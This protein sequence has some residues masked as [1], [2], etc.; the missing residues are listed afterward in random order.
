M[1]PRFFLP[2]YGTAALF[3]DIIFR[4]NNGVCWIDR[5]S[6]WGGYFHNFETMFTARLIKIIFEASA[7]WYPDKTA[8]T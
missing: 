7:C 2:R 5:P 1:R 8:K 3:H 6:E 4:K